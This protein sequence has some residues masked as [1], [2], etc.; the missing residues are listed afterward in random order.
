MKLLYRIIC[1]AAFGLLMYLFGELDGFDLDF[2]DAGTTGLLMVAIALIGGI[3][4]VML[5]GRQETQQIRSLIAVLLALAA[6]VLLV[7]LLER[8]IPLSG[9]VAVIGF[10]IVIVF[11]AF[12]VLWTPPRAS[13]TTST[14]QVRS[15]DPD[16][17]TVPVPPITDAGATSDDTAVLPQRRDPWYKRLTAPAQTS[18]TRAAS[19]AS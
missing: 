4:A 3:V 1:L 11:W 14:P 9:F 15:S 18:E 16:A 12:G 7:K 8:D 19:A 10:G 6:G 5:K 2:P 13:D 17:S